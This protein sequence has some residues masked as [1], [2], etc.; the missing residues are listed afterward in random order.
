MVEH[1]PSNCKALSSKHSVT[2]ERKGRNR[3]KKEGTEGGR[4]GRRKRKE[5][6]RAK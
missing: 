1:L 3:E 6:S 5:K 2:K 4:K